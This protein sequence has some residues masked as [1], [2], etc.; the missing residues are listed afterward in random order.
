MRTGGLLVLEIK[1]PESTDE[2]LINGH[3]FNLVDIVNR[4][5]RRCLF[6]ARKL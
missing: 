6:I 2:T 4:E 3:G 1:T 5:K